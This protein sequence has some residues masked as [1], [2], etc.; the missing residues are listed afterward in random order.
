M[1]LTVWGVRYAGHQRRN[2]AK[3]ENAQS[4]TTAQRALHPTPALNHGGKDVSGQPDGDCGQ[5]GDG[6]GL[7]GWRCT[8]HT[9]HHNRLLR[10]MEKDGGEAALPKGRC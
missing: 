4:H 7:L 3:G 9:I 10:W 1:Q 6:E 8:N 5:G 2:D